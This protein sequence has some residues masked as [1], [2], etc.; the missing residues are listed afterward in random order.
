M[1]FPLKKLADQVIVITGASSG[2]GLT[3]ARMAARAGARLVLAARGKSALRELTEELNATALQSIYVVADVTRPSDVEQIAAAALSSFGHFDT[4]V[5]NAGGGIF[6]RILD[7]PVEEERRLFETNFW[8]TVYGCRAAIPHLSSRGGALINLGS[9]ASDRAL[10]L[11]GAYSASK[12]AVK[13][14]TDTLRAELRKIGAPV[15][16]TLIKPTAIATPF[17]KHAA[18]Y[19]PAQPTEPPP[20]Y[21]PDVVAEA[22]LRAAETPMRDVL[23][24]GIAPL[25]SALGR[26][27]VRAGDSFVNATMF[28]GQ[29]SSRIAEAGDNK[30]FHQ[31]SGDLRERAEYDATVLE[32]SLYTDLSTRP[33]LKTA[34]I[35][36]LGVGIATWA[37]RRLTRSTADAE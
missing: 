15:S 2:I 29:M 32:R 21:A 14:Y 17:F 4:W 24:G 31:P 23:V 5:N 25:Q 12:H 22:I 26:V 30:I 28:E 10:P 13:A 8:G 36:G 7:T 9:V 18:T 34:L 6:G 19:M 35:A 27:F 33:A 20:M 3:T 1:R 16:V 11:Q 37:V